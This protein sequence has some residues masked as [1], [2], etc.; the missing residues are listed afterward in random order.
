MSEIKE[1]KR[2]CPKCG[3]KLLYKSINT[4]RN[5]LKVNG[6]CRSCGGK[7]KVEE[8]GD[9]SANL[10]ILLEDSYESFYWMGFILADGNFH[11]D[12]LQVTLGIKDKEHLRKLANYLEYKLPMAETNINI[13][14]KSK[15]LDISPL[16][17]QKFDIKE[18]KTYNPPLT[19]K[20][21]ALDFQY[22]LLA[23]F[24]DGDGNIQNQTGRQ[25]FSLRIKN[26]ASWISILKE[27]NELIDGTNNFTKIENSGY[28]I[29]TISNTEILKNFRRKIESFNLP[30]LRRKWDKINYEFESR[31]V[32]AELI[33]QTVLQDLK[34][35]LSVTD[36][37]I[38]NNFTYSNVYRIKKTYYDTK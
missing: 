36:I 1:F 4:Y 15:N 7:K 26:H 9:R 19:I 37:S 30:L 16:I 33:K 22:C 24:I 28:A 35:G 32:G 17:C 31:L 29:L 21:F 27:F 23:G 14:I 11:K 10:K 34:N 13:S 5:A 38:K 8:N 2:N 6:L 20:N 18:S 3:Q 25:D 12:R